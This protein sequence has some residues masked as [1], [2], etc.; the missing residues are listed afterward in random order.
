MG[1]LRYFDDYEIGQV[2]TSPKIEI[3]EEES[4]EFAKAWDPQPFHI[5][6]EAAEAS[7]YGGLTCCT[8]QIF[9]INSRLGSM[10]R[11]KLAA[12][13]GLGFDEMRVH[14]PMRPGDTVHF[15][16]ECTSLRQSKTKPD[17]GIIQ[18]YTKLINQ[19]EEVIFTTLVTMMVQVRPVA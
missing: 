16:T 3:N 7:L 6:K 18:T 2:L 19:H 17:R 8:A 15:T 12:I 11:P 1:D 4:I 9:A 10:M 5:D 14:L 13:A